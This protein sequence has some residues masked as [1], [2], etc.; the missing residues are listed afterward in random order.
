MSFPLHHEKSA[1]KAFVVLRI[2]RCTF[3]R[4]TLMDLQILYG[5]YVRMH[6]EYANQNVHPG[7]REDVT[8]IE[9]IEQ[10]AT[11][12][13][14][15]PKSAGCET[16]LAAFHLSPLEYRRHRGDLILT[17]ALF[18]HAF[19]D[20]LTQYMKENYVV[21]V[22][23]SSTRGTNAVL[24]YEWVYY[25]C[26]RRPPRPTKS[27]RIRRSYTQY[28]ACRYKLYT[29]LIT[30][31][32]GT[33]RPVMYALVESEQ[34]APIRRVFGLLKEMMGEQY[35]V[36]TFVMDNLAAQMRA[37][38]V[39]F[40]CDVM[41]CYFHIRKAI[42]KHTTPYSRFLLIVL[43]THRFRQDLQLLR[44]TDPR[45]VSY[46]TARWLY[47]TRKWAIHA[48]SGM[49]HFGSV[50]NN[51]LENANGRLKDWVHHDTLEHAIQKVSRHAEWL[52]REFEMHTSY[53]CDR[54]QIIEGDGYDL[55]VV[56]RMTTYACSLV[57]RYLGPR[58]PRMP[59]GS[60]GTNKLLP[61]TAGVQRIAYHI[62]PTVMMVKLARCAVVLFRLV[63]QAGPSEKRKGV[64]ATRSAKRASC[65]V[66]LDLSAES[67]HSVS[68]KS[69]CV[70]VFGSKEELLNSREQKP[71][72][73]K[74]KPNAGSLG[75]N[76]DPVISPWIRE[77]VTL[78]D[79]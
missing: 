4:I 49:V 50:I 36:R 9:R 10:A 37:A 11:K 38:S 56:C 23:S 45:F 22:R 5:A 59:Y 46:L 53:H 40:A 21:F 75:E 77:P 39:V 42:R 72:N 19:E 79:Q 31:G 54:R 6:L 24:R 74:N 7:R 32:M 1:Q 68:R 57:L 70:R 51:R 58:P 63:L 27:R 35:P 8:L 62:T 25:K 52:M 18:E 33:G 69:V 30:Y 76:L 12:M 28:S 73:D 13:V 43:H 34:F 47:I 20:A 60:V 44:R 3:S 71:L 16:R 17:Y 2:I 55:N 61:V 14:A 26:S 78:V 66:D 15:G 48:H 67:Q 64:L 65:D 41:L 29:F